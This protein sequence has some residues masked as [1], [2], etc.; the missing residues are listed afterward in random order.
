M[1]AGFYDTGG[2]STVME[3]L[4]EKL[5]EKGH[6]VTVG[7]LLFRRFPSKGAYR[8]VRIPVGNVLKLRRFLEDFDIIHNHHPVTNFLAL[9]SRKPFVY[10]Y[11]GAPNFGMGYVFRLSMISSIRLMK[12]AFD[13]VIAVSESGAAELKHYFDLG[14]VHVVYNGVDTS[15]FKPRLEEK[16]RKGEPQ[17]LF[18]GNLYEHKNVEELIVAMK[19]LVKVYPRAYLQIVGY[20][21]MYE[22]LKRSITKLKLEDHVE[23]VGRVNDWELPYYYA[24]CD[25][26]DTASR[27]EVFTLPPLEAM[28]CGKPVV[29]SSIPPHVELLVKSNAG[30][31]YV[32]G[33]IEDLCK[34]MIETYK[35]S[36]SYRANA[37]HF[38]K[39]HDWFFVANKVL[40]L[41]NKIYASPFSA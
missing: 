17:F 18:V 36:E 32:A 2:F 13:A 8:V 7:A 38:A 28:A 26:Y 20:G 15:V 31:I 10:H 27:Y 19:E 14:N 34:K 41:Y 33:N 12:H 40:T 1:S 23:L 16:F 30:A 9:V 35:E 3:K 29:A 21:R 4:A 37:V 6:E 39:E 25:V 22:A 5:A 11:H 24:S